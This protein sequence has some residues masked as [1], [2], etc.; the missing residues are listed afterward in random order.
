M[1]EALTFENVESVTPTVNESNV[2]TNNNLSFEGV[3]SFSDTDNQLKQTEKPQ[4]SFEG[5]EDDKGRSIPVQSDISNLEKLEYGFDK[6]TMVVGNMFRIGKAYFQDLFDKDK[7]FKDYILENEKKRIE[8]LN[9]EHWKFR[10]GKNDSDGLVLA[11]EIAS[12]LIDPYYLFGYANPFS[13]KALSNPISSATLNA[14]LIG[15]DVAID[16]LAKT[17]EIDWNNVGLNAATAGAIG[18][19]LPV[20]GKIIKKYAPKM[21]ET[22]INLVKNFIDDKLAKQNNL[23]NNQLQKIKNAAND[24]EVKKLSN[25]MI[26]WNR[27]FVNPIV[28]ETKRFKAV[29]KTLLEQRN[30][31][32]TERGLLKDIIKGQEKKFEF[33]VGKQDSVIKTTRSKIKDISKSVVNIRKDIIKAKKESEV[34]KKKLIETQQK[35]LE[36]W[37]EL[38]AKRNVKILENLQKN[39]TKID[40]AA[41]ALLSV[42]VKPLV[43]GGMGTVGGILFGDDET[44]LMYWF[45]AGAMAGQ[46]QKMIQKSSK[47]GTKLDKGRILGVIDREWTQLQLQKIRDWTSGTSATKLASYGGATEQVGKMLFREVDSSV[48]GRSV[49]SVADQLQRFYFRKADNLVQG[50]TDAEI[51]LAVSINRGKEITKDTPQR[52]VQLAKD[53]KQYIDEFKN[54]SEDAGFFPK[55]EVENYFP[56][57]L[58][59]D[60]INQSQATKNEFIKTIKEIYESLG[61]TGVIKSGKNKGKSRSQIL[62]E[63]YFNGHKVGQDSVVNFN[64]LSKLFADKN[65]AISK[66]IGVSKEGDKFIMTPVTE[67]LTHQRSLQGPYK[68]VEEVLEK[69]GYL[70]N[71]ARYIFTKLTNDS[72]KSI[73]FARQFGTNGEL[74]QPFFKS[75]RDKYLNSGLDES[76]ALSAASNE[77]KLVVDS[78]DAYFDRYGTAM[79]GAAKSTAA[80]LATLGNLNMLG[81]VTISSLGDIIQP[82][83]N[84][85]NW[86]SALDGLRKTAVRAK[87]ETGPAKALNLDIDNAIAQA[88]QRS[89][90]FEGRNLLLNNSWVGKNPTEKVNNI[91]FKALGLEWLTGYARRFA[92]NSGVADAYYLS[93]TISNL[94]KRNAQDSRKYKQSLFF[95]QRNYNINLAQALQIGSSRNLDDAIANI[96]NKRNLNKAGINTANRDALIPQV[97]NRLLFT[98]SNNQWVR[99]MGQFLSWAMAKSAQTNKILARIEDG[100]VKTLIK[101]LAVIPIYSGV[102][103]LR[104]I[105]KYGEVVTDYDAN[106]NRWW[107]EGA[108]LSGMFGYLPE[109]VANRFIGPGSREAWFLFP[110]AA[111]IAQA[112]VK[113]GQALWDGNTD[114]ALRIVNERIAPLPN[115]R[116]W[117]MK[118]FRENFG[119]PKQGNVGSTMGGELKFSLGGAVA[120]AVS[121]AVIKRGNT[122]ITTTKGTYTKTNKIFDDFNIERVHD[123]GSGKG[124]GSKEFKNKIVTSHEPFVEPEK[125]IQ[126]KGK[127]PDYKTAD[128]VI[129]KDG[130]KSKDGIVNLNVLNVIENPSERIKVVDQIGKLLSDDGIAIITT[131]GD[132]VINQAKKSKNA[133]RYLDGW[134]F[135]SKD[136]TFQKGFKQSELEDFVQKVLGKNFKVEKIPS[137]YGIGT[138]GVLIS[139]IKESIQRQ[140]FNQGDVVEAEAMKEVYPLPKPKITEENTVKEIELNNTISEDVKN[141]IKINENDKLFNDDTSKIVHD[142]YEGGNQTIGYGHKLTDKERDSGYVYGYKISTLTKEQAEDIFNKDLEIARADVDKLIDK[143]TTDP[144]AYGVLVE[145]AHQIGGTKLPEFKKMLEAVNRKDYKEASKQML[146]NYDDDGQL[147]GKTNW[148]SQTGERANRLA[149]LMANI[150]VDKD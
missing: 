65:K 9:E 58:N 122:A 49:T 37:G 133:T 15:G 18:A 101:T 112:P 143:D 132:D 44:D 72:V 21:L 42:A 103:S 111:Q 121:K 131:R 139:R 81:R 149:N 89:A 29:E 125:I 126:A 135:G 3:E 88:L 52:V 120:K 146:F 77:M 128:E 39:E 33:K 17:G 28:N 100:N 82:F 117:M 31:L 148:H 13:L 11:G 57:V 96:A 109:L 116:R 141:R 51:A 27:S 95:L 2:I 140:K 137:K 46:M 60:V 85:A 84:S 92:Y 43:G 74:L 90:G 108:R 30:K 138:S 56:R 6:E 40:Y 53:F 23:S 83:Q 66:Q 127:L 124:V 71:D 61:Y 25:Q 123:F 8:K 38:V 102:Q 104:E 26:E 78:I 73:A 64:S 99:L 50:F 20:G 105:A 67:H 93:K 62:A 134:L 130:L 36:K 69:K 35:K 45:A 7:T 4:L 68:L 80:I 10:S 54:L 16:D 114:K 12:V 34:I 94:T 41:R 110:P 97:D 91:M 98:Q 129:L 1:A 113:A 47:F 79:T 59:W 5:L 118:L 145:M 19:V 144:V 106:N 107:A 87:N 119:E 14:L 115:W 147:I 55:K 75:I 70:V 24:T 150:F 48:S 136:K 22:E 142:S 63:N 32:I 76:K 86:R